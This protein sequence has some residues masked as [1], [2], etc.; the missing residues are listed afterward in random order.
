MYLQIQ[1]N[2][3]EKS[4][5][6][7]HITWQTDTEIPIV[8]GQARHELLGYLKSYYEAKVIKS[9]MIKEGLFV[10]SASTFS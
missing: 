8:K 6:I 4:K 3:N 2:S 5:R 9:L 1:C 7:F 10:N